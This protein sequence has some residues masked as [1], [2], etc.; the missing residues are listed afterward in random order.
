MDDMLNINKEKNG[1]KYQYAFD[2]DKKEI[3]NIDSINERNRHNDYRCISCNMKLFPKLG[4]IKVHHFAHF[5]G[6]AC[7]FETYIHN[8]AKLS[9]Y[10]N[11]KNKLE[12]KI[13]LYLYVHYYKR[14]TVSRQNNYL[15]DS[16]CIKLINTKKIDLFN[17]YSEVCLEKKV[18]GFIPDVCLCGSEKIN[19]IFFE[20]KVTHG[21]DNP[22]IFSKNRIIEFEV[23]DEKDA[24]N[25]GK[26]NFFDFDSNKYRISS[27]NFKEHYRDVDLSKTCKNI[28]YFVVMKNGLVLSLN[29]KSIKKYKVGDFAFF[30]PNSCFGRSPSFIELIQKC[31]DNNILVKSCYI[32]KYRNHNYRDCV[33]NLRG[34]TKK[35]CGGYFSDRDI[36]EKKVK[37]SVAV[38]CDKYRINSTYFM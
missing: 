31:I 12:K 4:E 32:C 8:L 34:K 33:C 19:P 28:R 16:N 2:Y 11:L 17:Y 21:C 9:L 38:K 26:L 35:E 5:K 15:D 25:L 7:N 18:N 20:I 36:E 30:Y 1:I 37:Q 10:N 14:C 23:Y 13:P 6:C 24:I 22:K 29:N 27:Y 3:V